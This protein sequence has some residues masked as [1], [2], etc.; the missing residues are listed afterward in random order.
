MQDRTH[1]PHPA[2]RRGARRFSVE[3]EWD[4]EAGVW[5]VAHSDVPGLAT[6]AAT[7]DQLI[8][9]LKIMV[10]EMLEL[11]GVIKSGAPSRLPALVAVRL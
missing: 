11:N 6:E 5:F 10:P 2:A 1:Q 8:E 3:A 9:K 4:S 7:I